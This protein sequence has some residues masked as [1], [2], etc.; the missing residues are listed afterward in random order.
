MTL[1]VDEGMMWPGQLWLTL[2]LANQLWAKL[3]AGTVVAGTWLGQPWAMSILDEAG[4]WP[5]QSWEK[6]VAWGG[7]HGNLVLKLWLGLQYRRS[8]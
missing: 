8:R 4:T 3:D 7:P 2:I 1:T 6:T 5:V